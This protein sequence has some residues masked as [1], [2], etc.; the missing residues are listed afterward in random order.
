MLLTAAQTRVRAVG[1]DPSSHPREPAGPCNLCGSV[2][3]VV[4]AHS[5][6]YGFD[7]RACACTECGLVFL[8]PRLTADGY[9]AFYQTTYRPLVSAF[10]DRLIDAETVQN[11][12]RAYAEALAELLDPF[13]GSGP[14]ALLDVGGSTGVVAEALGRRFGLA[15][16]VL[17]PAPAEAERATARG[18]EVVVGTAETFA[19]AGRTFDLVLLC[20]T[21]DHLLDPAAVLTG[22]RRLLAPAGIFFLDIVDF[23]AAYLRNGSVEAA[24]KID[25]PFSF[26]ESTVEAMLARAGLRVLLKDFAADHLHVGYVCGP[27]EPYPES[28]PRAG[29]AE[30]ML[31]EIR[32]VQ[33]APAGR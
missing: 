29:S 17:D 22:L 10:H 18:L 23:R 24:V 28:L 3:R 12:Q 32:H 7:S 16:V 5:D 14:G 33:N 13:L 26:T 11:E 1:F 27:A 9:G 15:A 6:R 21:I 31:A 20:Q 25:H 30:R 2:A 19:P 8:D 4:V